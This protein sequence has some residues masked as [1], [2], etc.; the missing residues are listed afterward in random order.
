MTARQWVWIETT[1]GMSCLDVKSIIGIS[2]THDKFGNGCY[3]L[4]LTSGTIF[5]IMADDLSLITS[6]LPVG[7]NGEEE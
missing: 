5:T 4:H 6:H 1:S 2:Y 3:D 7:N